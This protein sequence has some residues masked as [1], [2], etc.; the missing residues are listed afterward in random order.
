MTGVVSCVGDCTQHVTWIG[1]DGRITINVGRD[2]AVCA[3]AEGHK[4]SAADLAALG[5]HA[6]SMHMEAMH[7][8]YTGNSHDVPTLLTKVMAGDGQLVAYHHN[9]DSSGADASVD[10]QQHAA[11]ASLHRQIEKVAGTEKWLK[12]CKR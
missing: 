4:V 3:A 2:R 1:E 8:S 10:D 7:W 11:L 6:R 5:T 12:T 9:V